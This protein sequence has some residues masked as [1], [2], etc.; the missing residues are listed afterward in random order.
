[1]N[2]DYAAIIAAANARKEALQAFEQATIVFKAEMDLFK[3]DVLPAVRNFIQAYKALDAE[4]HKLIPVRAGH[5][6]LVLANAIDY[7]AARLDES[8]N[9][10]DAAAMSGRMGLQVLTT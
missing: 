6:A 5:A 10:Q 1:M 4:A 2:I 9:A 8:Y 7:S 3:H